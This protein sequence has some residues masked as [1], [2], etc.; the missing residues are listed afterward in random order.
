LVGVVVGA[1][2]GEGVISQDCPVNPPLQ[3][4]VQS[5]PTQSSMPPF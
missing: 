3:R 4:H 5:S 1:L 2:V